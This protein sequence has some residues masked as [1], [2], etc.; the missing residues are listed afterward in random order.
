MLLVVT[1][2]IVALV[3]V[4]LPK[5]TGEHMEYAEF[6]ERVL[7]GEVKTASIG[8]DIVSFQL[9][10]GKDSYY[11]ENPEYDQ[12][13]EFLLKNHVKVSKE[14]SLDE[15]LLKLMDIIF[16]LVF[17]AVI[18]GAIYMVYR[19]M[20]QQFKLVRKSSDR[21][22]DIAG[23]EQV[24]KDMRQ[25][26]DFLKH[27]ENY[28]RQGIRQPQGILFVGPPGN[29]KTMFARAL[30]GEAG[31]NFIAA[32]ATDF[33]SMYMAIGPAKIKALFKKARKHAP[34][35]VFIDEFDGIGEKRNYAG[36]GID[37]ENNRMIASLLN[38]LDGFE[39]NGTGVLVIGATNNVKDLDPALIR[40]GR[41]DRK[42]VIGN[43]DYET[44][45]KLLSMY[46]KEKRLEAGLSI[47][48]LARKYDGLSCAQI[49]TIINEA[50]MIAQESS[51]GT[52]G[53]NE[54]NQAIA[55]TIQ[56]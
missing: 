22:D 17:F 32:K 1:V 8:A 49:E 30:A 35:I 37:K 50:A 44:R 39:R 21:F 42:Y 15:L 7:Q 14:D 25:L 13:K 43:P 9:R 3:Y 27:P 12:F 19:L 38:E 31:I 26:V 40:A 28:E 33:Q 46:L 45:E 48:E 36:H 16:D 29:G 18:G 2:V 10:E 34:C 23:M 55:R 54:I 53:K 5:H 52:I 20:Y 24:K 41:F 51:D 11:T 56:K 6:Y 4:F 47:A